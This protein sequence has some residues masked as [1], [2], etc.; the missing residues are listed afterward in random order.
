MEP[1]MTGRPELESAGRA[2]ADRATRVLPRLAIAA[3]LI[4]GGCG[5]DDGQGGGDEGA[6][7]DVELVAEPFPTTV[8]LSGDDLAA[9]EPDAGDGTLVFAPAPASL[10]A[11][12]VGSILVGGV[13]D[14]SPT[15]LL[16]AVLAV[17]RDGDRLTLRTA[18]APIQ[19]AYKE[20][21]VRF[22]K[23]TAVPQMPGGA[24]DLRRAVPEGF[25]ES[26]PFNYVLFDGDGDDATTNDRIAIE[27][28]LGGG[29][30]FD[31][32]LDVNWGDIDALPQA[33]TS[34]LESLTGILVGMP[35]DC[36]VD[37]LL[38]EAKVTFTVLPE[39]HA[40]A[41]VVG[42]AT[43][44]YEKE[45]DLYSVTLSP[46][47]IGPIVFVPTVDVTA[48]L[49]GAASASFSTGVHGSAVFETSVTLSS[50]SSEPAQ[51]IPPKLKS[52]DFGT[53]PTTISLHASA[54]VGA[55]ARL[56]LLL[57][58]VTGPY[59]A[60]RAYAAIDADFLSEPCWGLRAGLD[61]DLGIKVTTPALPVLGQLT[62]VDW[63]AAAINALDF[64]LDTG[65]CEAP[66]EASTLPPGSGPD[67]MNYAD[68]SYTPWS[69][70]FT[71]PVEGAHAAAPGNGVIYSELHRTIDGHY[72]RSGYSTF[73]LTKFN[74]Q[75]QLVWARELALADGGKLRPLRV[76]PTADAAMM[77]LSSSGAEPIVL[78]KLGQDG[79][80]LDAR[81]FDVPLD[82]CSV[83]VTALAS[84]GGDGH[85]VAGECIGQPVSFLLHARRD[86]AR[87]WLLDSGD[88]SGYRVRLADSIEGDAF[89]AGT[90]TD[91]IDSMFAMRLAPDGTVRYSKRYEACAEAP[92]AIPSQSIVGAQGEV[93][94]A[95]SGGAQH[96]GMIVRLRPDGTVGFASFP[97]FG[98]G[99]GSVF[100]LDSIA[101]LP[102]TGYVVGGSVWRVLGEDE[103]DLPSAALL[104][105]DGAG[106]MLWG[107]RYTFG[108]AG[109]RVESGHT[110]VRLTDDGGVMATALV[111][112]P[113]DPLGGLLW[114]FKPFAKDG[115][116]TLDGGAGVVTPLEI[117]D[118][119]CSMT[120]SN[121]PVNVTQAPVTWRSVEVTSSLF[122]IEVAAQTAE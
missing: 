108:G 82:K 7:D 21:H 83:V 86:D 42:A 38:P 28:S 46:I 41:K 6:P 109:A 5:S 9:L 94:M 119:P 24:A 47:T 65:N 63:Q 117:T 91:G 15:G 77:V 31:F 36:S 50:K 2:G 113:A 67:A 55:G 95:G 104:G 70:T 71:P 79:S 54:K 98:F 102:T 100:V 23:S 66:P 112:D 121:R 27:G 39:V 48:K 56:N 44:E 53:H 99:A 68:P 32:A 19:L 78:T 4:A 76:R 34:C 122:D 22:T 73:A 92:D 88:I 105:L 75:G 16:R 118:L 49:E 57:F 85:Y 111:S 120:D 107:N 40:D 97:G 62:L 84:D 35:P 13:S 69:R 59:A 17:E 51:F 87:Y 43:L 11:V 29:F 12:K 106:R 80:V 10:D 1:S 74:E 30:D 114:A 96:N 81:A 101:E 14:S 103:V 61:L 33:V 8:E 52:S 93:T 20:L 115:G 18:Q 110:G 89:L 116:I 90:M 3:A 64:E 37:A 58:G 45:V 25:S 72:V 60:A 26:F